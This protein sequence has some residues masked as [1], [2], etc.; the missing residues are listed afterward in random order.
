MQKNSGKKAPKLL[1]KFVNDFKFFVLRVDDRSLPIYR[2]YWN[3]QTE[4]KM[5]SGG[6]G[7]TVTIVGKEVNVELYVKNKEGIF[8]EITPTTLGGQKKL[9]VFLRDWVK[10]EDEYLQ[11]VDDKAKF[12]DA[13]EILKKYNDWKKKQRLIQKFYNR[14]L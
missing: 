5:E 8:V 4:R 6:S 9:K 2:E 1:G 11:T 10:L 14:Y 7:R 12:E 13:E 3:S